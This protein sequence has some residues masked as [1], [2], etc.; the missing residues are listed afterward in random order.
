MRFVSLDFETTG[1][2]SRTDRI[3]QVGAVRVDRGEVND[4]FTSYVSYPGKLP[5]R[6]KRLT[7]IVEEHLKDAPRCSEVLRDLLSFI[8][9]DPVIAHNAPFERAF[10]EAELS[11]AKIPLP[12]IEFIDTVEFSRL[13][14]PD[15][16]VHRLDAMALALGVPLPRHHDAMSDALTCGLL[17]LKLRDGLGRLGRNA[18]DLI[19]S[20]SDDGWALKRH[21]M[22]A[23]DS[24]PVVPF[25]PG[26]RVGQIEPLRGTGDLEPLDTQHLA[27]L[28]RPGSVFSKAFSEYEYRKEQVQ[29]MAL[30]ADALNDGKHL[31]AEAGTGIGKSLAYLIP[32]ARFAMDNNERVV[33]STHTI[34]LQEQLLKKDIPLMREALGWDVRV[35]LLKGR[36]NYVCLRR[37]DELISHHVM[38][39]GR[40]ERRALARVIAWLAKTASGDRGEIGLYGPGEPVWGM[41][42][43][44]P[45]SCALARCPYRERCFVNASRKLA[46]ASHIVVVNHSLVFSDIAAQNK[47][48]PS[49]S[50][51]VFDEAHHLEDCATDHLGVNLSVGE[52]LTLA[53]EWNQR[54]HVLGRIQ[55]SALTP[56]TRMLLDECA[57]E[58]VLRSQSASSHLRDLGNLLGAVVPRGASPEWSGRLSQRL[59]P[60]TMSGPE[61]QAVRSVATNAATSLRQMASMLASLSEL[62]ADES[63]HTD[64]LGL[65]QLALSGAMSSD[66]AARGIDEVVCHDDEETVRWLE[67]SPNALPESITLRSAPVDVSPLLKDRLFE[68]LRSVT[69]TSA[70]LSVEGGFDFIKRRLGLHEYDA[71]RLIEEIIGAPF[72]YNEQAL[73]CI[74]NDMP[75]V[76]RTESSEIARRVTM[77]LEELVLAIGGRT[78][79]LF[80]S[81]RLLQE[82][83]HSLRPLM[84]Q[85]DI[86]L[87]AQGIDGS[88]TRLIEELR[89]SDRTVVFGSNSF[90]EGVDV[91]G[92]S[93]SCVLMVRLPFWPPTIPVLQARQEKMERAGRSSF[94]GL[95]L[96]QA[97]IRF[98]QGF[99]RLI[100]T[101][102]D[103]G[104]VIV[105]DQRLTPGG[106]NYG[107]R[108]I[109]SLPGPRMFTGTCSETITAVCQWLEVKTDDCSTD[110]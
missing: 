68:S 81:H 85:N 89:S 104:A 10:L 49:Y 27:S 31:L 69:M 18:L 57:D 35:A 92:D 90:W 87:L 38:P 73:L 75:S 33:V 17:F 12:E 103:R 71:T 45:G 40:D 65:A 110:K 88:R 2:D 80:T 6:V 47:V 66:E 29:L 67:A 60:H 74:P 55:R 42:C 14:Y 86:C 19:L 51:I 20:I 16:Q 9:K 4:S 58:I 93:L 83:Y 102:Q 46:A 32:A 59:L 108:F 28:L 101:R 21:I 13:A 15:M 96:P 7:G 25:T 43:A 107:Q 70:T 84:E 95:A 76:Q 72:Q 34:H 24:A 105:M 54:S 22:E 39:M 61:W 99:G 98:K 1:T 23:R 50:H 36:T 48:I 44:T 37:F 3:I 106:S 11:R 100:R 109:N 77:F 97:V 82:V 91:P 52:M 5:V 26:R 53:Q 56:E 63:D 41:I 8:G 30:V 94:A 79:V 64:V 78:L 62:L